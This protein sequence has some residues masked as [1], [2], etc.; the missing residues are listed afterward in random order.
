MITQTPETR[1][2]L[3]IARDAETE[4]V[5]LQARAERAALRG[6]YYP[7][8]RPGTSG[9]DHLAYEVTELLPDAGYSSRSA[10]ERGWI[11]ACRRAREHRAGLG[12]RLA[13]Y[14]LCRVT[15]TAPA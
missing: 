3:E 11:S 1:T 5:A 12:Y 4:R 13:G 10:A 6:R 2:E 15:A 14:P 9:A 7:I 8:P